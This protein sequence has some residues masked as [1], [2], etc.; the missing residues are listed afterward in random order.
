MRKINS[1]SATLNNTAF[2]RGFLALRWLPNSHIRSWAELIAHFLLTRSCFSAYSIMRSAWNRNGLRKLLHQLWGEQINTWNNYTRYTAVTLFGTKAAG[3]QRELEFFTVIFEEDCLMKPYDVVNLTTIFRF[4]FIFT[5]TYTAENLRI[6][7]FG[8][9]EIARHS[10]T[11]LL[12]RQIN[13]V[14]IKAKHCAWAAKC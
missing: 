9:G 8:Y 13:H 11:G 1:Y 14:Q 5:I 3:N 2:Y 12:K 10:H 6:I 7:G 4:A